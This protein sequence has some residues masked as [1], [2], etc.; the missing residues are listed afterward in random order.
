MTPAISRIR[1]GF[2]EANIDILTTK[3]SAPAVENNPKLNK[4]HVIDE[5]LFFNPGLATILPTLKLILKLRRE[6][7]SCAVI[8][9]A[10]KVVHKFISTL[11]IRDKFNYDFTPK[12]SKSTIYLNPEVHSAITAWK[13]ADL[14]VNNLSGDN[15]E[16]PLLEDLRYE[17]YLS[18]SERTIAEDIIA[19]QNLRPKEFIV[20]MPGGGEN[21]RTT[22]YVRRWNSNKFKD[23]IDLLLKNT[24]YRIVLMGG[25]SDIEMCE[26]IQRNLDSPLANWA[27]SHPMRISA[28]IMKLSRLVLVND[29]GPLHIAAALGVPLVAIFGPT[30]DNLKLPPGE[31]SYSIKTGISC[32]PCYYDSFHA[33]IHDNIKCM[34]DL[35]VEQVYE[36]MLFVLEKSFDSNH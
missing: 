13:L 36:K 1:E 27:G 28:A 22:D 8:F 15:A 19:N 30:G 10:N 16:A 7:Y 35:T 21:P 24:D 25:N 31:F 5:R 20:V 11:G 34:N 18:E 17:W 26:E 33:C 9:H 32:S 4:F 12:G 14:A 2:P 29:T 3:W 23:V 6:K